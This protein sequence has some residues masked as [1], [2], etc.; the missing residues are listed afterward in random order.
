MTNEQREKRIEDDI[1]KLARLSSLIPSRLYPAVQNVTRGGKHPRRKRKSEDTTPIENHPVA[2]S[3]ERNVEVNYGSSVKRKLHANDDIV[4]AEPTTIDG[5]FNS[6]SSDEICGH[7]D[8]SP[9]RPPTPT[10][11]NEEKDGE[12]RG[13]EGD[14]EREE[15]K[16]E[17]LPRF[18]TL[19]PFAFGSRINEAVVLEGLTLSPYAFFS[20]IAQ[21]ELLNFE[22]LSPRAFVPAVLSPSALIAR[23]LSPAAFRAEILSPR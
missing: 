6:S 21:P 2:N 4:N 14:E 18:E 20:E 9:L 22:I 8:C 3:I 23:V 16:R 17:E 11:R 10:L 13:E 1:R 12:E 15:E 19:K 7:E 5:S